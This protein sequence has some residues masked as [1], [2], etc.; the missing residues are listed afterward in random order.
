MSAVAEAVFHCFDVKKLNY[1]LLGNTVSHLHWHLF[2]RHAD[3]PRPYG[4]VYQ[5]DMNLWRSDKYRPDPEERD[6]LKRLLLKE[7]EKTPD[8]AILKHAFS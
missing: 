1:E 3:D 4:P 6:Q 2:P 7:L 5:I 8:I